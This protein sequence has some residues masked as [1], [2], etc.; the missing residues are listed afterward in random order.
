MWRSTAPECLRNRDTMSCLLILP[1]KRANGLPLARL[2]GVN[3]RVF[4][5]VLVQGNSQPIFVSHQ[6]KQSTVTSQPVSQKLPCYA[7]VVWRTQIGNNLLV[8]WFA[9][10]HR[11][12]V[13]AHSVT[14][15]RIS[16]LPTFQPFIPIERKIAARVSPCAY[17]CQD[18]KQPNQP[19]P[20]S[21][22]CRFLR[23]PVT[24]L[25]ASAWKQ[26]RTATLDPSP[27][28]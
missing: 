12:H 9:P 1:V 20:N 18:Q 4:N 15:V 6:T 23:F 14:N 21:T 11:Q 13:C 10:K 27:N 28:P 19:V 2:V 24:R 26:A 22:H 5:S 16:H 17:N 3:C 8:G 7:H 25:P